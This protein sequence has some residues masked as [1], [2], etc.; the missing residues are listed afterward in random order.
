MALRK[1]RLLLIYWNYAT[2]KDSELCKIET[3]N[4]LVKIANRGDRELLN[5]V[6]Y[7]WPD[8]FKPTYEDKARD[9]LRRHGLP[10]SPQRQRRRRSSL[11]SY[12]ESAGGNNEQSLGTGAVGPV[13]HYRRALI[14]GRMLQ[15]WEVV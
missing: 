10:D 11:L 5:M 9:F 4:G 2:D 13:G 14:Y 15:T 3:V 12:S 6:D 7:N 8:Y 1:C